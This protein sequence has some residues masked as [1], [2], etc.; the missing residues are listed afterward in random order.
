MFSLYFLGGG[1]NEPGWMKDSDGRVFAFTCEAVAAKAKGM[2]ET[3][4]EPIEVRPTPG[5]VETVKPKYEHYF[6]CD[7]TVKKLERIIT[8]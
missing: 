7:G 1:E 3:A 4:E 2:L 6:N 8:L 5:D